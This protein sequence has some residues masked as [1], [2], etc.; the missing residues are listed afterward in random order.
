MARYTVTLDEQTESLMERYFGGEDGALDSDTIA[1]A[2]VYA[3]KRK[4]AL[5]KHSKKVEKIQNALDAG[6]APPKDVTFLRY[7]PTFPEKRFD[8]KDAPKAKAKA[9]PKAKAKKADPVKAKAPT[10]RKA[11]AKVEVPAPTPAPAPTA[12][13]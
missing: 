10:V 12:Q 2:V 13:A 8:H 5:A 7:E 1:D 3:C 4:A 11:A 9:A 6:K